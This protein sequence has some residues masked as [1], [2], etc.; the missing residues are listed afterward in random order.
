MHLSHLNSRFSQ[1]CTSRSIAHKALDKSEENSDL[2]FGLQGQNKKLGIN[3]SELRTNPQ[4]A[5]VNASLR[6]F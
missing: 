6:T 5:K 3:T 1:T 2:I 4:P